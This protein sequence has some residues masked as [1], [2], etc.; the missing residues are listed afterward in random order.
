MFGPWAEGTT[1]RQQQTKSMHFC[2]GF[3]IFQKLFCYWFKFS[4]KQHLNLN[5]L[6]PRSA[7]RFLL[8]KKKKKKKAQWLIMTQSVLKTNVSSCSTELPVITADHP[9]CGRLVCRLSGK[10]S[11]GFNIPCELWLILV[12]PHDSTGR[13]VF[14]HA[15]SE[16]NRTGDRGDTWSEETEESRPRRVMKICVF[17]QQFKKN[18]TQSWDTFLEVF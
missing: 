11:P 6:E 5:I 15:A 17:N 7:G 13:R 16:P 18:W 8:E 3:F 12:F 9:S 10:L 14:R 1:P 4:L 2:V